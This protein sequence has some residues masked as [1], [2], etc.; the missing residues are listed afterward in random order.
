MTDPICDDDYID[1]MLGFEDT[2][3]Q[4]EEQEAGFWHP[5]YS[6]EADEHEVPVVDEGLMPVVL[7]TPARAGGPQQE[8]FMLPLQSTPTTASSS[9]SPPPAS[10]VARKRQSYKQPVVKKRSM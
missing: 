2:L 9:G 4:Q 8:P 10:T 1:S 3:A 5:E 6:M 7:T